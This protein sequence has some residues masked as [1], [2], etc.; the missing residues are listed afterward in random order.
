MK[1]RLETEDRNG[2]G[3]TRTTS[4]R[5][6]V[7]DTHLLYNELFAL[8]LSAGLFPQISK[9]LYQTPTRGCQFPLSR[10]NFWKHFGEGCASAVYR[11]GSATTRCS[12]A[13]KIGD[14]IKARPRS[15]QFSCSFLQVQL[16]L[17]F[18]TALPVSTD[19]QFHLDHGKK[20]S[21]V[22]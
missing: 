14:V 5:S 16:F 9:A 12:R 10:C 3:A 20:F 8:Y 1:P 15:V 17:E 4:K 22:L 2:T 18:P 7:I 11:S 21:P 6:C 13:G 19:R